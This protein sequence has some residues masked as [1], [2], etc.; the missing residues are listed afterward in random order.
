MEAQAG[1][2]KKMNNHRLA[3]ECIQEAIAIRTALQEKGDGK[4]LFS[5]EL[6][7]DQ[8]TLDEVTGALALALALA[9]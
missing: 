4:A 1:V 7:K 3:Q 2:H 6:E 5:K 8:G 9:L